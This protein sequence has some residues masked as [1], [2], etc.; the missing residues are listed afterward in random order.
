MIDRLHVGGPL[1]RIPID[2]GTAHGDRAGF[3]VQVNRARPLGIGI[4]R[5][6][7]RPLLSFIH[8]IGH[9]LDHQALGTR[10]S[11]ASR[12]HPELAEWRSAVRQSHAYRRLNDL[13]RAAYVE[14]AQIVGPEEVADVRVHIEYL[15]RNDEAWARSY[16]QYVMFESGD[17]SLLDQVTQE[18]VVDEVD[19]WSFWDEG[20]FRAVHHA[21]AAIFRQKGWTIG[22]ADQR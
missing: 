12:R 7:P 13:R 3:R 18:Q 5:D 19:R 14:L 16:V 20:D 22:Y 8:E 9:F 11:Y 2:H 10:G 6:E 17:P 15:L 21:I 1:P 4:S